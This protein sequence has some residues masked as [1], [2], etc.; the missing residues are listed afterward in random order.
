MNQWWRSLADRRFL[1][2]LF[3]LT[4]LAVAM[5]PV[6]TALAARLQKFPVPIRKPLRQFDVRTLEGLQFVEFVQMQGKEIAETEEFFE[7]RFTPVADDIRSTAVVY[8]LVHYYTSRGRT[9]NVPHTP[10][11]CYRQAGNQV[12][13]LGTLVVPMPDMKPQIPSV[14]AKYVRMS[15]PTIPENRDIAVAYVFCVN[16]TFYDDREKARLSL[17]MPWNRAVYFAKIECVT[18]VPASD[19]LSDAL[20]ALRRTLGGAITELIRNH[21]PTQ[22]DVDDAA[23]NQASG[24]SAE[25]R[26]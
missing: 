13:E 16:G 17:A 8:L 15:H 20:E 6:A 22:Q 7:G 3:V 24:P 26:D 21:F 18:R 25:T 10:E 9:P 23:R 1:V 12:T 5:N 4:L 19:R 11:V 14:T 2:G